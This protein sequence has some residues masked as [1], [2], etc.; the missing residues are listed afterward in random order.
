MVRD[1]VYFMY[2]ALHGPPKKILVEG[3]NAALLDIDFGMSSVELLGGCA[4]RLAVESHA[5]GSPFEAAVPS[6]STKIILLSCFL[7]PSGWAELGMRELETE[8]TRNRSKEPGKPGYLL[9]TTPLHTSLPHLWGGH[10]SLHCKQPFSP[11]P[12]TSM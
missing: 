5:A 3:A 1:G 11:S 4:H 10:L 12:Q 6:M 7:T 2:E 9:S 8:E